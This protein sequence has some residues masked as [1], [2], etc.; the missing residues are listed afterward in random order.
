MRDHNERDHYEVCGSG[1]VLLIIPGGAGHPM[2]LDG[3]TERLAGRF[4]VVTYDPLGLA[5]GRL[6]LPVEDQRVEAWSDGAHR[7]LGE[8]LPD[9]ELAYVFGTSAGGIVALDLLTRH[10][11]RLRQVVAHEPP[12]VRVLPDAARQQ[13]MFADVYDTYRTAGLQAAAARI[14]AGLEERTPDAP[15]PDALG[16]NASDPEARPL[17]PTDELSNPMALSLT[18]VLRQFT[19]YAPDLAALTSLSP[20]L[21][22]AAGADSRGQL[23]Y[24]TATLTAKL[25]GS[26]F[27]EFPG[28]HLGVATH[29]AEFAARLA[30]CLA[31]TPPPVTTP[32]VP[33]TT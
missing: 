27:T 31:E 23:L 33:L 2:G 24:R 17:S 13:A 8:V 18:R 15:E 20:C 28:G 11:E 6:G 19:A 1:P 25:S 14:S 29:P 9:G 3:A 12:V 26:G 5:H 4:T 16:P 7:V 22:L 32:G 30:E 21:T 10:S